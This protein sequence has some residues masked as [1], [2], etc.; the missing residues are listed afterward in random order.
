MR[1][2]AG[3]TAE[4]PTD[5]LGRRAGVLLPA[6]FFALAVC[7][8]FLVPPDEAPDEKDHLA[9]VNFVASRLE[10]PNQL[11]PARTVYAQGLQAPLYY[12]LGAIPV[13]LLLDDHKVD[14]TPVGNPAHAWNGGTRIDVPLT[15]DTSPAIFA[16]RADRAVFYLL[17]LL[18]VLYAVI[19]VRY[20]AKIGQVVADGVPQR[21]LVP[22][23]AATLPQFAFI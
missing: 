1:G 6:W 16:M 17:R 9:Y 11:D 12:V 21:V 7:F 13:R 4:R 3:E 10:L 19:N 20:I 2:A 15:L 22:L 18:S 23:F 14:M 5:R 8:A